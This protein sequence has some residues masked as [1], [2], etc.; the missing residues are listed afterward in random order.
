MGSLGATNFGH[1]NAHDEQLVRLGLLAERYFAEDPNT[2]LLKLRQLTEL[3]AQLVASNVG[4]FTTSEEKQ[5]D[6]LRRLQDQGIVPREVGSL[7]HEVRRA[8]NDANHRLAGDHRTALLALPLAWQLGVWFHR[9]FKDA[10]FKSGPFQTPS[11]PALETAE[12]KSELDGLRAELERYRSVHQDT[13]QALGEAQALAKQAEEDRAIWEAMAAE[14]EAA[15]AELLQRLQALQTKSEAAPPQAI[16]QFVAAAN[17]AAASIQISERDTRKLIDEQLAL[18]GWMVDSAAHTFAKGARLVREMFVSDHADAF[19]RAER[20]YG[21]AKKPDD[22]I[23][24]FS[25]FIQTQGNQI[26]ALVTVLTHPRELTRAQLRERV[27]ALDKAGFTETNLALAWREMT[28]QGIAAR[29]VGYI[30]QAAIGD[31]LIPYADLIFKREGGGFNRL[32]KVFNGQLQPV[33]D[34]FNDALWTLPAA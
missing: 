24:A 34:A 4:Q 11:S 33:L 15:K 17:T 25:E 30:R 16:A 3:L 22:D 8:G 10:G 21:K 18:A 20:G 31:A 27:L 1:L 26:P 9:T 23:R 28:N 2:C 29:I 19:D 13:S 7:F 32:D 14:V 12:L 6:L 5:A